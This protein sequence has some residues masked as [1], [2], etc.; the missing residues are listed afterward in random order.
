VFLPKTPERVID[1]NMESA[2]RS[3]ER[4]AARIGTPTTRTP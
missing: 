1:G 2:V 4:I 3:G